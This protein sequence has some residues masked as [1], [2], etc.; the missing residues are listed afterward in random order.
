MG[1]RKRKQ[2]KRKRIVRKPNFHDKYR[3]FSRP[4]NHVTTPAS[5]P[6]GEQRK[7]TDTSDTLLSSA[8]KETKSGAGEGSL[9]SGSRVTPNQAS[10]GFEYDI[11]LWPST[12]HITYVY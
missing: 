10:D 12:D 9:N 6:S 11:G 7:E 1:A 8:Q 4:L 5:G 2:H 3:T